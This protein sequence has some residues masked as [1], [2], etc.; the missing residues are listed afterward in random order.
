MASFARNNLISAQRTTQ[1]D[2]FVTNVDNVRGIR[3]VLDVT[4]L[5]SVTPVLTVSIAEFD[6]A[7]GKYITL[8]TG[9]AVATVSTN[10][11]S[12]HPDLTASAN[13]IAKD[14][15]HRGKI[16]IRVAVADADACTYSLGIHELP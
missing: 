10:V 2:V 7:S 3:V 4:N 14:I 15:I 5:H 12:I 13:L 6:D 8:L 9:G 16:R 11:Y 1:Q